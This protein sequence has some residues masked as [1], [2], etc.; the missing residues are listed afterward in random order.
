[1]S[2][3]VRKGVVQ[4][5]KGLIWAYRYC[6]SP[7][8]PPSCRFTPTCSEYALEAIELHGPVRGSYL[9]AR[10][11]LRCHPIKF[12]GG[13]SG[14]DPVPGASDRADAV[15][16][17]TDGITSVGKAEQARAHPLQKGF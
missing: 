9:A 5:L 7:F 16:C 12:L 3:A 2:A 6:I 13:G 17:A 14:F 11:L 1:M 15:D 4:I 8:F 10:R